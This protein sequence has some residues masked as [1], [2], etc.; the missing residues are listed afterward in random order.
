MYRITRTDY[1]GVNEIEADGDGVAASQLCV[2]ID[3]DGRCHVAAN[4]EIANISV[5]TLA[6]ICVAC[7]SNVAATSATLPIEAPT[8]VYVVCCETASGE[9]LVGKCVKQ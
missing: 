6:G 2:T 7:Q 1:S 5:Y 8:G 3:A 4:T 9:M